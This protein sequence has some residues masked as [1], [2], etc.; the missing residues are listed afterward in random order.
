MMISTQW[1][2]EFVADL[3]SECSRLC[4]FEMMCT[5][6]R[7]IGLVTV[8]A[9]LLTIG[10]SGSRAF[11]SEDQKRLCAPDVFRL[12]GSEIPNVD[13]ITV[14]MRRRKASLSAGCARVF[15]KQPE[16]PASTK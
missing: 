13:R 5:T 6:G 14:C 1:H 10:S 2:G 8:Q 11:T 15:D 4:K 12:C 16:Q 9:L 7:Y 3:A